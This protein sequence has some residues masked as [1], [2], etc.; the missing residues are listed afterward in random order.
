MEDLD[1]YYRVLGLEPGASAEEVKEAYRDLSK[2]WHPDRFH[3][4]PR[5]RQKGERKM[6]EIN[7]AYRV[8][9]G[10]RPSNARGRS[11]GPTP[12]TEWETPPSD[13]NPR[14]ETANDV[15]RDDSESNR[16]SK[17]N[18]RKATKSWA[19]GAILGAIVLAAIGVGSRNKFRPER[20]IAAEKA[21]N[22]SPAMIARTASGSNTPQPVARNR[23]PEIPIAPSSFPLPVPTA[24]DVAAGSPGPAN[25]QG[26]LCAVQ[27]SSGEFS[28]RTCRPTTDGVHQQP[29]PLR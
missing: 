2:V 9:K 4:Q 18:P 13:P 11:N 28:T 24:P 23:K 29:P 5:L 25:K 20:P 1:Y 8:L 6:K 21:T 26:R 17:H 27:D 22:A 12:R 16:N 14:E 10:G 7:E 19:V 3:D 15:R